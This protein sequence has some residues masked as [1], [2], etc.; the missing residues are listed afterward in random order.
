MRRHVTRGQRNVVNKYH[1]YDYANSNVRKSKGG[2]LGSVNPDTGAFLKRDNHPT[3]KKGVKAENK[4]GN[5]VG[6]IRGHAISIPTKHKGF[7]R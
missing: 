1:N 2:H 7:T 5:I 3:R 6:K 4:R